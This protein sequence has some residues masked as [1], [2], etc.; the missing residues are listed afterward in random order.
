VE[1]FCIF[2][3]VASAEGLKIFGIFYP[4]VLSLSAFVSTSSIEGSFGITAGS[5]VLYADGGAISFALAA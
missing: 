1:P 5:S 2:G 4:S 3:I